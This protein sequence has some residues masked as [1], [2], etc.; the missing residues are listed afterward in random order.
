M[1]KVILNDTTLTAIAEAI[2]TKGGSQEQFLPSEMPAAIANLP[3][4]GGRS[5]ETLAPGRWLCS[6]RR[7]SPP[8]SALRTV[9]S[10]PP[11]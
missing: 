6:R 7:Q 10:R 8:R 4:G 2:R 11:R 1:S 5:P 3:S 9:F